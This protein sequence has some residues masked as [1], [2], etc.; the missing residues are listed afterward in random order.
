M[1]RCRMF[2]GA[3]ALLCLNVGCGA[4]HDTGASS[5]VLG[6]TEGVQATECIPVADAP[7]GLI[8]RSGVYDSSFEA[9]QAFDADDSTMW[10]SEVWQ[11]PAWI[12]YELP[13]GAKR[14]DRYALTFVNGSLTTRAP[15][16]F[17]LEGWDGSTWRVLDS[18][19]EETN[20]RGSER[21]E[22]SVADPGDYTKYRLSVSDDNDERSGIVVVSLGRLELF[23]AD[24]PGG[25]T[26]T[27]RL[28]ADPNQIDLG[29]IE[30]GTD[31]SS[32][33]R[34]TADAATVFGVVG[35]PPEMTL[36]CASSPCRATCNY[37]DAGCP[38]NGS[39]M[40][41][42]PGDDYEFE[43]RGTAPTIAGP[44]SGNVRFEYTDPPASVQ[45]IVHAQGTVPTSASSDGAI[46]NISAPGIPVGGVGW[47][48]ALALAGIALTRRRRSRD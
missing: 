1:I 43:L 23:G 3:V 29:S 39:R 25:R 34:V 40:L 13:G 4:S 27:A 7:G 38:A 16:D 19:T 12:G 47:L 46:C 24:C 37:P 21:R 30:Q 36:H 44:F 42:G 35:I 9:W 26:G 18:R 22:Y 14:V 28:F 2:F 17:T 5:R 33:F 32:T 48:P 10:I 11:T 6:L 41:I 8:T 15:K 45:L 20:W 31:F